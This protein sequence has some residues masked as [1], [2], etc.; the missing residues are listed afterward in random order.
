[1]TGQRSVT[2]GKSRNV[3][4][5]YEVMRILVCAGVCVVTLTAGAAS[6]FAQR[7]EAG[8]KAGITSSTVSA[9]GL[10]GFDPEVGI[11]VLVGGWVSVGTER[12]R[13]QPEL[14][15]ATRRLSSPS[16]VGTVDLSSRF[17][18]VP[19]LVVTRWRTDRRTRPLLFGGPFLAFISNSTQTIGGIESDL[20]AQLKGTDAGVLL[21]AG[22]DIGARRGAVVLDTRVAWGLR[23][24]SEIDGATLKSRT[25]MVSFGYRF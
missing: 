13:L 7:V 17:V 9:S 18:D 21:G 15:V 4:E 3:N 22:L 10:E 5:G 11:G 20:D 23:N 25:V 6:A 19:I 1:L 8:L 16:P 2:P 24:L 12:V 14:T